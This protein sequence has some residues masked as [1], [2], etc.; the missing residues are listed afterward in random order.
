MYR[1]MLFP[2]LEPPSRAYAPPHTRP[3]SGHPAPITVTSP[4]S[5]SRQSHTDDVRSSQGSLRPTR[6]RRT[7]R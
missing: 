3:R 5:R 2:I 1:S 4:S 7:V 6:G